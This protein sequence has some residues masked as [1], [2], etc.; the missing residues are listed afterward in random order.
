MFEG[1]VKYSYDYGENWSDPV[2]SP[3]GKMTATALKPDGT[4]AAVLSDKGRIWISDK[5]FGDGTQAGKYW[6]PLL[7]PL[8]GI[9]DIAIIPDGHKLIAVGAKDNKHLIYRITCGE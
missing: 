1:V 9:K 5:K 4:V 2:E 3:V 6:L 8:E 7:E